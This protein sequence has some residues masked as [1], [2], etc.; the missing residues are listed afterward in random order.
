[1][2]IAAGLERPLQILFYRSDL[3]SELDHKRQLVGL[4]KIQE[5]LFGHLAVKRIATFI[6]LRH[7]KH[8]DTNIKTT[9]TK[10]TFTST[11]LQ[12][13]GWAASQMEFF[14]FLIG[15]RIDKRARACHKG[16][17]G[18]AL[19]NTFEQTSQRPQLFMRLAPSIRCTRWGCLVSE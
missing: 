3:L 14:F 8:L 4:D 17:P 12:T 11:A 19:A 10:N 18:R 7:V 13:R 2:R 5:V 16:L 15:S 1:M 6:K 9:H